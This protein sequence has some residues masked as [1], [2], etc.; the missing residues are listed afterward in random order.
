M[1]NIFFISPLPYYRNI[2]LAGHF[3]KEDGIG[4]TCT[5]LSIEITTLNWTIYT[6]RSSIV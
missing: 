6:G 5:S 4:G 2:C 1:E 3:W